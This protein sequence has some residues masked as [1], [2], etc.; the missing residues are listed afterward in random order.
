MSETEQKKIELPK[1]VK[2]ELVELVDEWIKSDDILKVLNDKTK[3]C[4]KN[5]Q[6]SEEQILEIFEKW[7]MEDGL[8]VNNTDRLRKSVSST[9]AGL[10]P[11]L[12]LASIKEIIKKEDDAAFLTKRI[13]ENRPKQERVYLKR[14]G[15]RKKGDE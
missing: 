6:E 9:K 12:V 10:K 13:F 3:E 7:K 5:K 8:T 2:L 1:D 11:D 15:P 4:K 14:T